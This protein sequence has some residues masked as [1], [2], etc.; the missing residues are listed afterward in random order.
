[1]SGQSCA[2]T[3]RTVCKWVLQQLARGLRSDVSPDWRRKRNGERAS[4]ALPV[5]LDAG[6]SHRAGRV[7]SLPS[8]AGRRH[9]NAHLFAKTDAAAARAIGAAPRMRGERS[10]NRRVPVRCQFGV[11]QSDATVL[12]ALARLHGDVAEWLKAAVC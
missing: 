1:M 2:Q 6:P 12:S 11:Y 4:F 8:P 3:T 10:S 7:Q 9:V 5:A